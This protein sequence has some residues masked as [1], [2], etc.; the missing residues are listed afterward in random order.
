M[1]CGH[2]QVQGA[3]PSPEDE[4]PVV[5]QGMPR[6]P[7]VDKTSRY[8]AQKHTLNKKGVEEEE[9]DLLKKALSDGEPMVICCNFKAR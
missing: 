6:P 3:T 4:M 9:E 5:G 8:A 2:L 7:K 1:A